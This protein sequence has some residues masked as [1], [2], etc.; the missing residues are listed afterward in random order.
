LK[1]SITC[2]N[3][4]NSF[5][6]SIILN[7]PIDLTHSTE[8]WLRFYTK[9]GIESKFD[10]GRVFAVPEEGFGGA[11]LCGTYSRK[12][13]YRQFLNEPIYD[14]QQPE[15]VME[16]MS[17]NKFLGKR[18]NIVFTLRADAANSFEGWWLDDIEIR[19]VQDT[20]NYVADVTGK[21][22]TLSVWPNP[23]GGDLQ[24]KTGGTQQGAQVTG[25]LQD[26]TGR[27]VLTVNM[28]SGGTIKIGTIPAGVYMLHLQSGGMRL[29]VKKIVKTD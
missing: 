18:V 1:S 12:G 26:V 9:W 24:I 29:P 3:Y 2:G 27:K 16:H 15:W 21:E 22:L 8:A 10:C 19:T 5:D 17:L 13:N 4:F 11:P 23:T 20:P 28:C 25:W 7:N 14:G 6:Y